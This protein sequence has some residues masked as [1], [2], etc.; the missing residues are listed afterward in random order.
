MPRPIASLALVALL[1]LAGCAGSASTVPTA[2]EP[3][4]TDPAAV[5]STGIRFEPDGG[6]VREETSSKFRVA[7]YR[8]P[9]ADAADA[10]LVVYC[11]SPSGEID[12]STAK[13]PF[14]PGP[15]GRAFVKDPCCA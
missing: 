3:T 6:W 4:T 2:A 13:L 10:S 8:L 15:S 7:Q 9:G 1:L 5:E 12:W 14:T 11:L